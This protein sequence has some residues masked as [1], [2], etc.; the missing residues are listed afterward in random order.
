MAAP[1]INPVTRDEQQPVRAGDLRSVL[2]LRVRRAVGRVEVRAPTGDSIQRF[3]PNFAA[4][5]AE[6]NSQPTQAAYRGWS[7]LVAERR[8]APVFT[9]TTNRHPWFAANLYDPLQLA[10]IPGEHRSTGSK[11]WPACAG[12][13][14]GHRDPTRQE[15]ECV[16]PHHSV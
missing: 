11:T 1:R 3:R 5:Y 4:A 6:Q 2:E 14:S 12:P 13:E 9:E 15:P 10:L 16:S 7:V 8:R